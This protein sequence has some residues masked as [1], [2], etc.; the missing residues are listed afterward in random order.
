MFA[1]IP[2]LRRNAPES[3]SLVGLPTP[4]S[5]AAPLLSLR[6]RPSVLLWRVQLTLHILLGFLLLWTLSPWAIMQWIWLTVLVSGFLI[7]VISA[8][9]I[10]RRRL[11]QEGLLALTET[12]WR[13]LKGNTSSELIL[14][15]EVLVWSGLIILPF[16]ERSGRRRKTLVLLPDN[17]AAEDL[18]R[19]RV[20]LLTTVPRV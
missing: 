11:E 19:L 18:R 13:W 3:P 12:G 6:L 10:A 17:A 14:R 16:T 20:W 7:L 4:S 1:R 2:G 8:R 9:S 15:G 5:A